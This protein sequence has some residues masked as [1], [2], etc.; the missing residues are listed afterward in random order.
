MGGQVTDAVDA[1]KS[2][3]ERSN[4]TVLLPGSDGYEQSLKRWAESA[5]KKAAI[6][7]QPTCAEA[8]SRAILFAREHGFEIAVKGGGHSTSGSS[9][10]KGGLLVD[11]SKMRN[12]TVVPDGK[13]IIAEGGTIWE[14]VDLAASEHGL[15]T[16]GGTVNH[17]GVG[18]LTLGGGYGWLSGLYGLTIDNLLA[19]EVVLADGHILNATEDENPDLFWALRGAGQSFGVATSFT[20]RGYTQRDPVWGGL[21]AFTTD[22]LQS[23]VEFANNLAETTDGQSAIVIGFAAPAPARKPVV[24]AVAFYNGPKAEAEEY[25]KPLLNLNPVLNR[26]SDMPYKQVNAMLNGVSTHGDRKTQKGT[27]FMPPL[28]QTFAQSL[29]DDYL[30]FVRGVPD[31]IASVFLFEYFSQKKVIEISQT[32]MSFAN[33]GLHSNI[34]LGLR[35]TDKDNDAVCREWA[36]TEAKKIDAEL[37][38]HIQDSRDGV[39]QYGNYDGIDAANAWDL[40]GVNTERVLALKNKYDPTNVFRKGA[41]R[42]F[43]E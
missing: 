10:T 35:W 31:A 40:F 36:R 14:D 32:A 29:L 41:G 25:Y 15:S 27:A 20:F 6:V 18:G 5:E 24:L 12:V 13:M 42:L 21:L 39:G 19:V 1:L 17:T 33:R 23:V 26:T 2:A 8:V 11:L 3:L 43:V 4:S 22:K 7:V 30:A 16:V 28:S 37:K 38:K 34:L 9:S